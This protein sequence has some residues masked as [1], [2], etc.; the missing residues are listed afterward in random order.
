MHQTSKIVVSILLFCFRNQSINFCSKPTLL[1]NEFLVFLNILMTFCIFNFIIKCKSN[2]SSLL[3]PGYHFDFLG[4][5]WCPWKLE[6][7]AWN[8]KYRL[9]IDFSTGLNHNPVHSSEDL[10]IEKYQYFS[11][12]VGIIRVSDGYEAAE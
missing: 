4:Y 7:K 9:V 10:S 3:N 6:T 8:W 5:S 12:I 1:F 11:F 2:F